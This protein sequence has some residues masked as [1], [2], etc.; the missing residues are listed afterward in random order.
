MWPSFLVNIKESP[1]K[2]KGKFAIGPYLLSF[3]AGRS[4]QLDSFTRLLHFY[5]CFQKWPYWPPLMP[6]GNMVKLTID[7]LDILLH[8]S[9]IQKFWVL[10]A[11]PVKANSGL[12]L[13][14][15]WVPTETS[16]PLSLYQ[17]VRNQSGL[18]EEEGCTA[19]MKVSLEEYSRMSRKPWPAEQTAR[20]P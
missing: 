13:S 5:S 20:L 2:Y 3:R 16:W 17:Y 7:I 4:N 8:I 19:R 6:Y 15:A 18:Q 14:L 11:H 12:C 10:V 1:K 9:W